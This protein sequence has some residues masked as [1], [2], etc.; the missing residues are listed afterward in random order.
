MNQEVVMPSLGLTM[1]EGTIV[2]WFAAVGDTIELGDD[3]FLLET[4]KAQV[5]IEAPYQGVLTEILVEAGHTV[6]VGVPIAHMDVPVTGVTRGDADPL[7]EG[8]P[9]VT[10][11]A[12]QPVAAVA[13]SANRD[14]R[15][16][17][18]GARVRATPLTRR[19]AAQ[20]GV[21]LVTVPGSGQDARVRATPLARRR[22]TEL[23]VDLVNVPGS[24]PGG[25]IKRADV[26]GAA[27]NG[28]L[29]AGPAVTPLQGRRAI[30]ADRMHASSMVTAPVTL[31][32]RAN[33]TDLVRL[34]SRLLE[35]TDEV[36]PTYNDI[37][38]AACSVAIRD[39]PDIILQLNEDGLFRPERINIGL[40][41]QASEGL[42]VPV[43]RDADM[44]TIVD[45]ARESKRLV[46]G[47][48]RNRL[49]PADLEQGTF[50]VS[51]L[52]SDGIDAFTPII[53]L[54]QSAVLGVGAIRPSVE[55]LDGVPAVVSMI[56]LSLTFDHR[57]IDGQP[58]ARFLRR[59][60]EI[61]ENPN[62]LSTGID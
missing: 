45:L 3:L 57:T 52:G 28:E 34:R 22:A 48:L 61:L 55:V 2:E 9:V 30:I 32:T 47:V 44:R 53:N 17:G 1:E 60:A 8:T 20:L 38:V 56:T 14:D 27:D 13:P 51:N 39:H 59:V 54:P 46:D 25:R 23:G 35:H 6:A 36:R 41:V 50:T 29:P 10:A 49:N 5:E 12:S 33:A 19:R 4:E 62:A 31:T 18:E 40:A 16:G 7:S 58:A 37:I 15:H 24:G 21:G 43:I 42:I 11:T 26:E